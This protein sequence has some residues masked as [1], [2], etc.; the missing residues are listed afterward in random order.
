MPKGKSS[1]KA[2]SK[3]KS[4]KDFR[5]KSRLKGGVINYVFNPKDNPA[6]KFS[7]LEVKKK[8]PARPEHFVPIHPT[9]SPSYQ[10]GST[11]HFG[12]VVPACSYMRFSVKVLYAILGLV[13]DPPPAAA[14]QAAPAAPEPV[15]LY[16]LRSEDDP[17]DGDLEREPNDDGD[18]RHPRH[19]FIPE[20]MLYLKKILMK[21][22]NFFIL[23]F[24]T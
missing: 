24:F 8:W 21:T 10:P 3:K 7:E 19:K 6:Y 23:L 9:G 4:P 2:E 5:E 14:G 12:V 17:G 16:P 1:K 22:L 15:R 13:M 18:D 20:G 11:V